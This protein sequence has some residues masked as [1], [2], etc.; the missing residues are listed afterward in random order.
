MAGTRSFIALR[1]S[2]SISPSPIPNAA[3]SAANSDDN[4][5]FDINRLSV[6]EGHPEAQPAQQVE[7]VLG[8]GCARPVWTFEC[9]ASSSGIRRSRT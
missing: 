5:T 8:H 9:R 4:V 1:V 6:F 2:H 3:S 7:R